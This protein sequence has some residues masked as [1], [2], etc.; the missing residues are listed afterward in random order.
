[1]QAGAHGAHGSVHARA[2]SSLQGCDATGRLHVQA[3]LPAILQAT[4]GMAS[5]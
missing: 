3:G 1:M 2:N 5:A 4:P